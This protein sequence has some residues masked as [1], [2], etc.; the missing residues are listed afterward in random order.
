M[1]MQPGE[2]RS[3]TYAQLARCRRSFVQPAQEA[4]ASTPPREQDG[5]IRAV[6]SASGQGCGTLIAADAA[7]GLWRTRQ[8]RDARPCADRQ[9]RCPASCARPPRRR[10]GR[11]KSQSFCILQLQGR[12][13]RDLALQ[14][15][16]LPSRHLPAPAG[17]SARLAGLARSTRHPASSEPPHSPAARGCTDPQIA[18]ADAASMPALLRVS[19]APA[20]H[21]TFKPLNELDLEAAADEQLHCQLLLGKGSYIQRFVRLE[22][23][24]SIRNTGGGGAGRSS[25]GGVHALPVTPTKPTKLT[26]R[27]SHGPCTRMAGLTA[28]CACPLQ[29]CTRSWGCPSSLRAASSCPQHRQPQRHARPGNCPPR[30][31]SGRRHPRAPSSLRTWGR[32]SCLGVLPPKQLWGSWLLPCAAHRT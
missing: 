9:S 4:A 10:F 24:G 27:A 11:Q 19:H 6:V 12:V 1:S 32:S 25:W 8:A 7:P 31:A 16:A 23:E 5:L 2:R 28:R 29:A 17:C 3:G 21:C 20:M 22:L 15:C 30:P 18:F 13:H 14:V 26:P